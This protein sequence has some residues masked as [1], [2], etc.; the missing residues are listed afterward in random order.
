M[1]LRINDHI[2]EGTALEI[3]EQLYELLQ[4]SAEFPDIESY[5]WQMHANFVRSTGIDF[6]LPEG[7]LEEQACALLSAFAK[8]GALEVLDLD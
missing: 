5:I 6:D 2:H 7:D 1:K 8:A 3:V 4:D